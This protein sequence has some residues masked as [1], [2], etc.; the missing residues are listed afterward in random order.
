MDVDG[1]L[2]ELGMLSSV[3]DSRRQ[4]LKEKQEQVKGRTD[5]YQKALSPQSETDMNSITQGVASL[6]DSS[7]SVEL[8][9]RSP[10]SGY[11]ILTMNTNFVTGLTAPSTPSFPQIDMSPSE[12]RY[13]SGVKFQ[14]D[15]LDT[16]ARTSRQARMR[17]NRLKR[18]HK[19]Y[20]VP[21]RLALESRSSVNV[22][23]RQSQTSPDLQ[24]TPDRTFT[25]DKCRSNSNSST[26]EKS[27]HSHVKVDTK[28]YRSR[29][30]DDLKSFQNLKLSDCENSKFVKDSKEIENMSNFMNKLSVEE[31]ENSD[32]SCDGYFQS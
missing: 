20:E 16:E 22:S 17:L 6:G 23:R 4:Y 18:F 25:F 11:Q 26:P 32:N 14:C 21:W 12:S 15:Y 3:T 2:R 1:A 31:D 13:S 10:I 9:I 27:S 24:V 28:V 7:N 29:S 30:L 8:S 19:P 5:T